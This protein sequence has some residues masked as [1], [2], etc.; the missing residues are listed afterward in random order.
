MP[1]NN[2]EESAEVALDA[3]TDEAREGRGPH[4]RWLI[5]AAMSTMIMALFSVVGSLLAGI[6]SNEAIIDRQMQLR[7]LIDL[8]RIELEAEVLL[9]RLAV[10]ESTGQKSD[11]PSGSE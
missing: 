8:N 2:I 1:E 9:T 4:P 5:W 7:E 11:P 6:T 3:A 10:L